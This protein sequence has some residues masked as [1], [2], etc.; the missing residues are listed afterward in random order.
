[1]EDIRKGKRKRP[2]HKG[3]NIPDIPAKYIAFRDQKMS[4]AAEA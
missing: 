3:S 2:E 4:E 1:M